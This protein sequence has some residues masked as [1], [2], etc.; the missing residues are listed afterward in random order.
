MVTEVGDSEVGDSIGQFTAQRVP[1]AM[2]KKGCNSGEVEEVKQG[3]EIT[4]AL[5]CIPICSWILHCRNKPTALGSTCKCVVGDSGVR[6][7]VTITIFHD[8]ATS[9]HAKLLGMA[10]HVSD[11][12]SDGCGRCCSLW[13]R[14]TVALVGRNTFA[15]KRWS[16]KRL[17]NVSK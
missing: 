6:Q 8:A 7:S 17:S 10:G 2:D 9:S 1:K 5:S 15:E 3:T 13:T 11:S 12:S 4:C 14:P 16:L